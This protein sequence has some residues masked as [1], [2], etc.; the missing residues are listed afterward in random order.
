MDH[1]VHA[2]ERW[3][4]IGCGDV[5][6]TPSDAWPVE[7]RAPAGDAHHPV[8]RRFVQQCPHQREADVARGAVTA[9]LKLCPSSVL[10][11]DASR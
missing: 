3:I 8:N 9:T 5:R 6:L 7:V 11:R 4:E 1:G 2:R 10:V